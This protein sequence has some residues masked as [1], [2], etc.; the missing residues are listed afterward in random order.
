MNEQ[1]ETYMADGGQRLMDIIRDVENGRNLKERL[2]ECERFIA[3][4]DWAKVASKD[5][6]RIAEYDNLRNEIFA[7]IYTI[8]EKL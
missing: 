5:P 3:M 8:K 1:Y 6:E 7:V 2:D 4:L